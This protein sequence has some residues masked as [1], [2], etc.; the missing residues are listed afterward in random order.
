MLHAIL[1]VS[2]TNMTGAAH[3]PNISAIADCYVAALQ[4]LIHLLQLYVR[5]KTQPPARRQ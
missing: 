5:S 1:P 4:A 3:L 2:I